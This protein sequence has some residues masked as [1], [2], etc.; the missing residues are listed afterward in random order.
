[1]ALRPDR[2]L[3]PPATSASSLRD[4][5]GATR[6][7]DSLRYLLSF[8]LGFV[9]ATSKAIYSAQGWEYYLTA[10]EYPR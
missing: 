7:C 10:G 9:R 1:M 8:E 2:G 3:K 6:I 4:S 5:S